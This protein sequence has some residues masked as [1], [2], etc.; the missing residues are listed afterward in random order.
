MKKIIMLS[1][2]LLCAGRLFASP[3][4]AHP[5]QS[6]T[7]LMN[8]GGTF[9]TYSGMALG[10]DTLYFGNF[11]TVRTYDLGSGT[12]GVLANVGSAADITAFGMVGSSLHISQTLS[13][14]SPYPS[15]IGSVDGSGLTP[16]LTSGTQLGEATY[17]VYDAAVYNGSYYFSAN[18]GVVTNGSPVSGTTSGTRIYRLDG[19][20]VTEIADVGDVSGGLTF[21]ENGNLYY[22]AQTGDGVVRF[23]AADVSAGGLDL[24]DATT[25]VNVTGSSIDFLSTGEMVIT[26]G[27][28]QEMA[29]Y[30]IA[31]GLKTH[32]I[33]S[34][35]GADFMGKFVVDEDDTIHVIS[36]DWGAYES[37]LSSIVIPEPSS[38]VLMVAG[39]GGLVWFRRRRKYFF[40]G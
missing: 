4:V 2:A 40:R 18:L 6:I 30:D 17:A 28:G 21:D 3:I 27:F 22:A 20:S 36:T 39:A 11:D 26:T 38:V 23:D 32:D 13:Y 24:S 1:A 35:S 12:S 7:E 34:T 37:S 8:S 9:T 10:G 33:A 15:N 5:A 14:A 29:S 19:S 16:V 31:T 25:V